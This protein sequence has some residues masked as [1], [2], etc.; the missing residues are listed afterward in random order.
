MRILGIGALALNDVH[1]TTPHRK[2]D[3]E[4]EINLTNR[5]QLCLLSWLFK[6][7]QPNSE[8]TSSS[9][10]LSKWEERTKFDHGNCANL[11]LPGEQGPVT[12]ATALPTSTT[13]TATTSSSGMPITR[14]ATT[15]SPARSNVRGR[16]ETKEMIEPQRPEYRFRATKMIQHQWS[17]RIRWKRVGLRGWGGSVEPTQLNGSPGQGSK[18]VTRFSRER[19]QPGPGEVVAGSARRHF[20]IAREMRRA[21]SA[22]KILMGSVRVL[23]STARQQWNGLTG[24]DNALLLSAWLSWYNSDDD[25]S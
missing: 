24:E 25:A 14:T 22:R 1:Q 20:Y 15:T 5:Q 19:H 18:T 9:K 4:R 3:Q 16:R 10:V 17:G 6:F 12:L 21:I 13:I 11:Y 2:I 8:A 23:G 7:I